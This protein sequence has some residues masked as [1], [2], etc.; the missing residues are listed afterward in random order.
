M[1]ASHGAKV[2]AGDILFETG[3][4]HPH[5]VPRQIGGEEFVSLVK[6]AAL[7][8]DADEG[9][10]P[11]HLGI[12]PRKVGELDDDLR[13]A[14]HQPLKVETEIPAKVVEIFPT[15][16]RGEAGGEVG[17]HFEETG[18]EGPGDHHFRSPFRFRGF[19]HEGASRIVSAP[20]S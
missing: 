4:T 16:S 12:D 15:V 2:M 6:I 7:A 5:P 11:D 13:P 17:R 10:P 1:G 18:R 14:I 8:A 3:G 20:S 19:R 9:L